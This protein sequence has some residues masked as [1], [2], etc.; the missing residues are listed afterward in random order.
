MYETPAGRRA[1]LFVNAHESRDLVNILRFRLK[2]R[3]E[4][5][6]GM[7][8]L[9]FGTAYWVDTNGDYMDGKVLDGTALET[10][11]IVTELVAQLHGNTEVTQ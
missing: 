8:V 7:I 5:K 6:I 9:G 2:C 4:K 10:E 1:E 3:S 11:K